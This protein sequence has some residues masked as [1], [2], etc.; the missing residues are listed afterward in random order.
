MRKKIKKTRHFKKH[1]R[2]VKKLYFGLKCS[3]CGKETLV[4]SQDR[5][6]RFTQLCIKCYENEE[7][8]KITEFTF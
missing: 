3:Y 2:L 1:L 6:H 4:Y 7:I 8:K 5:L